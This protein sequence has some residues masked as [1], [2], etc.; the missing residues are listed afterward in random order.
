V[1]RQRNLLPSK[2]MLHRQ[3]E[4]ITNVIGYSHRVERWY[5]CMVIG[6]VL[7]IK[8]RHSKSTAPVEGW[9]VLVLWF[10]NNQRMYDIFN[11]KPDTK[12][13]KSL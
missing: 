8:R 11:I 2:L 4:R 10:G 12:D 5:P 6:F 9:D 7:D 13:W 1:I 3:W